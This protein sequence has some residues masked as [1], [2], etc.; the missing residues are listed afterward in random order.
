MLN[1]FHR[2]RRLALAVS[3]CLGIS[4]TAHNAFAD[5]QFVMN[6]NDDGAGSLR[7]TIK[8]AVDGDTIDM[9][10]MLQCSSITLTSGAIKTDHKNLSLLG[11][12]TSKLRITGGDAYGILS[13]TN[14]STD[15]FYLGYFTIANGH[16]V[17][18]GCV[19][20]QGNLSLRGMVVSGC[21]SHGNVGGGL[22]TGANLT[23]VNSTI[24]NNSVDAGG[25]GA[26]WVGGDLTISGS[27]VSGNVV[28]TSANYA[29]SIGGG[30]FHIGGNLHMSDTTVANNSVSASMPLLNVLGGGIF[31]RGDASVVHSVISGN[32]LSSAGTMANGGGIYVGGIAGPTDYAYFHYSSVSGNSVSSSSTDFDVKANGGGIYAIKPAGTR[33][34]TIDHNHARNGAGM[35]VTQHL[36]VFQST[37]TANVADFNGGAIYTSYALN[38]EFLNSTIAQNAT[39][40]I[41]NCGGVF[42]GNGGTLTTVSN[43]IAKNTK[44]NSTSS[45]C[46][47]GVGTNHTVT[48]AASSS[49]NLIQNAGNTHLP[50]GT[51]NG[52]PQFF[53]LANNGGPTQTLGIATTSPARGTGLN[54]FSWEWDQRGAGFP[55]TIGIKLDI[56]AFESA[57]PGDGDTVFRGG[58][59]P[60]FQ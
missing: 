12:G 38:T 2:H 27:T 19:Y 50:R 4:A 17:G 36:N 21:T 54:L 46:D 29:G 6:C 8:S 7:E 41:S 24:E 13:A 10:T 35:F 18:P 25:G 15:T 57:G 59:D 30:G 45:P 34:S 58:F 32:S 28:S 20:A 31:V 51:L 11:P 33:Y 40:A 39:N 43:I 23:V 9:F 3:A 60:F 49:N 53:Q 44:Y 14:T 5:I 1:S 42:F 56:G 16:G 52:D 55:R 47:I 48:I 26:A 22:R 37:I